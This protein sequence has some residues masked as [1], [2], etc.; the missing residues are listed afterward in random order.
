MCDSLSIIFDIFNY[1][2]FVKE[3][4]GN[5]KDEKF[6]LFTKRSAFFQGIERIF[7]NILFEL[8]L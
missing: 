5:K 1:C 4:K 6:K 7:S 3:K 2:T 8:K